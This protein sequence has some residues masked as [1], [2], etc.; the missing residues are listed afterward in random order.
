MESA[1]AAA[2]AA[3]GGNLAIQAHIMDLLETPA[4]S[5]QDAAELRALE[6]RVEAEVG[7]CRLNR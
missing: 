7:R 2:A 6:D 5:P 1:A 3:G 4:V